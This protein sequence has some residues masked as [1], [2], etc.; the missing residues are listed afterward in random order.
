MATAT[1][2]PGS[3]ELA[4]NQGVGSP[5]GGSEELP[6]QDHAQGTSQKYDR[7]TKNPRS[8]LVPPPSKLPLGTSTCN[9]LVVECH[10]HTDLATIIVNKRRLLKHPASP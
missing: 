4:A 5:A 6:C 9:R 10:T 8:L 1:S 3:Q 7:A 2:S